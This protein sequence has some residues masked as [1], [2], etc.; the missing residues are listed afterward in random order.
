MKSTPPAHAVDATVPIDV[1]TM[2]FIARSLT[3]V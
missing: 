3:G 1:E 2:P